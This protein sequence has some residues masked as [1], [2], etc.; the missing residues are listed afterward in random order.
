MTS[1]DPLECAIAIQIKCP[2]YTWALESSKQRAAAV[3]SDA[4]CALC[5]YLESVLG[6]DPDAGVIRHS[7]WTRVERDDEVT[8]RMVVAW[9]AKSHPDI[10]SPL[11]TPDEVLADSSPVEIKD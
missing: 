10:E 5:D 6:L 11:P 1:T 3:V 2:D 4:E 7:P 9:R 8:Y